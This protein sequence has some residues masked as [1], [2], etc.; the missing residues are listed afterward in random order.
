MKTF[1]LVGLKVEQN[2]DNVNRVK[3]IVLEDGLIINKEDGENHWLIEALVSKDYATFFEE[4]A[5]LKSD[6]RIFVTI[7]KKSNTPAQI[8]AKIKSLTILKEHMSILL[9]GRLQTKK[10][11]HNPEKLLSDLMT[12]GLS[13]DSLLQAFRQNVNEKKG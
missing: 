9:E 4:L 10:L 13:G 8:N 3:E 12:Q 11:K 2:E 5:N 6:L 1:K 7:S